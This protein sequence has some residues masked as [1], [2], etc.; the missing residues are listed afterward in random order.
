MLPKV[1]ETEP[2]HMAIGQ[3]I[4]DYNAGQPFTPS[5]KELF[6]SFDMCPINKVKVVI[7]NNHPYTEKGVANGLA[8]AGKINPFVVELNNVTEDKFIDGPSPKLEYLPRNGVMMLNMALTC[9]IGKPKD[10]IP[11]WTP[12]FNTIIKGISSLTKETI[13]VFVGK[14][15]E[16]VAKCVGNGHS[17]LFVPSVGKEGEDWNSINLFGRINAILEKNLKTGID[18]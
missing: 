4:S 18:W 9:P 3:L 14:D 5:L 7:I 1:F 2:F 8:F 12:V 15:V 11:M 16:H 13:F 10:H 17:K 6:R